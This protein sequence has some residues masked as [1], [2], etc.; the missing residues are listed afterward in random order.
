MLLGSLEIRFSGSRLSH[1]QPGSNPPEQKRLVG[2]ESGLLTKTRPSHQ[3]TLL[4]KRGIFHQNNTSYSH[5]FESGVLS[6]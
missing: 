4:V 3:V 5:V 2:E 1:G 6:I